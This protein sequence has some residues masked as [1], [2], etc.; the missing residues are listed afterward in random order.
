MRESAGLRRQALGGE[1]D[2]S[3]MSEEELLAYREAENRRRASPE[4][5]ALTGEPDPGAT[6]EWQEVAL[7]GRVLPVRVH[8]PIADRSTLPLVVHVHGGGFVG[9]AVQC[10]WTTSHLAARLPAV[11]VSVEHR[12]LAPDTPLSAAAA[13]GWDVLRHVVAGAEEWGVDPERTAV[14]GESCGALICALATV[15][16]RETGLRLRAQVLVNPAVDVTGAMFAYDSVADYG[17]SPTASLPQLRL[18]QRLAAPPGTDA[19]AVSPLHADDLGGLPPALVVLPTHDP[20]AD[21]GRR[22]AER[23]RAAGTPVRMSEYPGAPHAFL[24]LPGVV[25]AA[26]PARAEILAFLRTSLTG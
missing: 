9:T 8:R 19:R 3:S 13:D 22:Y 12:L 15:R 24:S 14:F 23:L 5:R 17:D 2:W 7:P 16:A 26:R 20:V 11:V 21:H 4:M 18:F 10:D 6:I 25:D 1:P